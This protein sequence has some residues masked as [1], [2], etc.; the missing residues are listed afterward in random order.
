MS[1]TTR[2]PA[3]PELPS[4]ERLQTSARRLGVSVRTLRRMIERG[5]LGPLV[6]I[7]AGAVGLPTPAVTAFIEW[8]IA[9]AATASL[10]EEM[11]RKHAAVEAE[12]FDSALTAEKADQLLSETVAN[13]KAMDRLFSETVANNKAMDQLLSETV[14]STK[15][16]DKFFDETAERNDRI[17]NAVANITNPQQFS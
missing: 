8:R 14:A 15:A 3:S 2:N 4:L 12:L 1:E 7:S 11:A 16:L 13:N 9:N 17:V 5:D 10:F 6:K